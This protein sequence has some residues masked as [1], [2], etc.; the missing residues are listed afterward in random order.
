MVGPEEL[1]KPPNAASALLFGS[2]VTVPIE[3]GADEDGRRIEEGVRAHEAEE[4]AVIGEQAMDEGEEPALVAGDAYSAGRNDD[5]KGEKP[6]QPVEAEVVRGDLRRSAFGIT[7]LDK[8]RKHAPKK[9]RSND[10]VRRPLND[11]FVAF[12][13]DLPEGTVRT[14]QV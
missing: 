5:G 12:A 13:A 6:D 3:Q 10:A 9:N 11:D 2:G 4:G 14:H 1:T 7:G 8:K